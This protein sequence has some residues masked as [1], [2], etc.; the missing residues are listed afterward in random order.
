VQAWQ[1][2]VKVLTHEIMNSI[3]PVASLAKTAVDLVQD[4]QDKV[5]SNSPILSD[6]T[7]IEDAV[8]TVARRSDGLIQFVSSYRKLTKL[9][10]PNKKPVSVQG[11]IQQSSTLARQSWSSKDIEFT[12]QVIPSE[13]E[14]NVD[15]DMVEQLLL[16]LLQNAEHAVA[17]CEKPQ[18][19]I[20]AQLNPRGHVLIQISDNGNGIPHDIGQ[21]VFVPFFT[22]KTTGSGVGLALARQIMIAHGGTIKHDNNENK[23]TRF[24]LTF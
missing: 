9:P 1:D 10:Q 17:D 22:T 15:A 14:V 21:K 18:I 8:Q 3:T 13:L 4:S 16:N 5:N 6:L 11:L 20:K 19:Q 7:D 2:L 12:H 24:S 23:G